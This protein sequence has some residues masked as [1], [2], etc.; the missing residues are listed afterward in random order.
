MN[1][2]GY[3]RFDP[4]NRQE[5]ACT[6]PWEFYYE[7]FCIY[8]NLYYVGNRRVSS[9]MIDTG[10]GLI[11]IDTAFASTVYLIIDAIIRLGFQPRE[12]RYILHTHGHFDHIQGTKALSELYHC[13]TFIGIN[14]APLLQEQ[15]ELNMAQTASLGYYEKFTP[16]VLLKDGDTITLGNTIIDVVETPGHSQGC[17]SYFFNV[18]GKK[19]TLRAGLPG[20]LGMTPLRKDLLV[21]SALPLSM[22][23]DYLASIHKLRCEKPDIILGAHP[24]H[25]DMFPTR[26][27]QIDGDEFAFV[28]PE[29]WK[30]FLD[31]QAASFE[32]FL[33]E[34]EE[35]E[36]S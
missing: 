23:D 34:E 4:N 16:D 12:L 5:R 33:R 3:D 36:T 1:V 10:D 24:H 6:H 8:G 21:Q 2:G 13:K 32:R 22:R 19:G 7:P 29:T 17:V 30:P 9:H 11:L 27:R 28:M 14:D 18:D 35:L 26:R 25:N 31:K 15:A 20:G